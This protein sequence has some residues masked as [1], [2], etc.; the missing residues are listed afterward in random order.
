[1]ERELPKFRYHPDPIG[2][3]AFKKADTPGRCECCGNITEYEY[4][5][6]FY[7]EHDVEDICPWC[8]A[9]GS[10]AKKYD[11]EFQDT[12]SCD[13]VNDSDKTDELIRRTPCYVGRQQEYWLAH[14]GDYCA[15]IGYVGMKALEDMGLADKLEDIYRKDVSMFD[16]EVIRENMINGGGL[17]GYLFRCLKCG[18]YQLYAGCD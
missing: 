15:F 8:I 3:G 11:G 12:A 9:D 2:T 18:K 14:C 13:E 1:M 4:D 5:G 7:S 17:Q 16:I 6:P 10:A